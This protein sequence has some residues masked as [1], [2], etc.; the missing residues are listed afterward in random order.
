LALSVSF[1]S[2]LLVLTT[3]LFTKHKMSGQEAAALESLKRAQ[4]GIG[5]RFETQTSI[6]EAKARKEE[7]W[8]NAYARCV[9]F[10]PHRGLDQL[11]A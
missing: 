5:S 9:A 6:D 8:K 7:E 4:E 2:V 11:W 1:L 10:R 3:V